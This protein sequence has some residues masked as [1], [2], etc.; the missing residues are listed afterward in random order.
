MDV[1]A[2]VSASYPVN[3]D[4]FGGYNVKLKGKEIIYIEWIE[5]GKAREVS[6]PT[7]DGIFRKFGMGGAQ[8]AFRGLV[9]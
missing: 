1:F 3:E 8:Q 7:T 2:G 9:W 5:A 6:W 4:I